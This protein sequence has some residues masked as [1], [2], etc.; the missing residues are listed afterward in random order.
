MINNAAVVK[1]RFIFN[2]KSGRHGG[3]A[4]KMPSLI[5]EFIQ[6]NKLDAEIVETQRPLHA[7]ELA[8]AAVAEG[9]GLVVAVGGDG[10][11]NEVATALVGTDAALGIVPRGSGNGLVRHL[12]IPRQGAAALENLLAGEVREIDSGRA[13]EFSFFNVMGAGFDAEISERFTRVKRR[14]FRGYVR[15]ICGALF[16][17]RRVHCR[18]FTG[19]DKVPREE[20][21]FMLSVANSD[22]FGNNAFIAPKARVDDGLFD[23]TLVRRATP[24]N[25]L[26]FAVRLMTGKIRA[27]KNVLRGS[28]GSFVIESCDKLPLLIHTDGEPRATSCRVEVTNLPRSLRVMV[29]R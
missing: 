18:I 24:W 21:F 27:N 16:S 11:M 8:Q 4:D 6:K 12:G 14:G 25:A 9:C 28:A 20:K 19:G 7:T 3:G 5:A 13:N 29:P 26:P 1:I 2:P 15:T 22:Q 10:T 23:L 17:F